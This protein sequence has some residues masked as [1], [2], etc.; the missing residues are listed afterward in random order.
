M[1][2]SKI[3]DLA[4]NVYVLNLEKD[5]FKYDILKR[6]LNQKN[7]HHE[8]FVGVDGWDGCRSPD[9]TVESFIKILDGYRD[10]G[11]YE[12]IREK[13]AHIVAHGWGAYRSAGAMGC[14]LSHLKIFKDAIENKY[15][16]ILLLQD[17]IYFH[18]QFEEL[19]EE[20]EEQIKRSSIFYLGATEHAGWMKND[21]HWRNPHWS[22]KH[23]KLGYYNTTDSSLGMLAFALL[24]QTEAV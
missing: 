22:R 10:S 14:V 19:L 2:K 15:K 18:N 6:K 20:R 1:N 21:W 8:R 16:K 11:L 23:H 13:G 17:D 12:P 24:S 4:D 3:N 5:S 7:I 9:K